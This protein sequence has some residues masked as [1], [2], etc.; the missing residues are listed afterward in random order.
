M[1]ISKT[2]NER[3]AIID[4][5]DAVNENSATI[6][7]HGES[8]A[9]LTGLIAH[10]TDERERADAALTQTL[11]AT[12]GQL[13]DL[14]NDVD[15]LTDDLIDEQEARQ[16]AD[17]TLTLRLDSANVQIGTNT[18]DIATLQDDT[19]TISGNLSTLSETV[20]SISGDVSDITTKL[21]GI[22]IGETESIS[23]AANQSATGNVTF[24]EAFATGSDC[25]VLLLPISTA[26][27]DVF[28]V[29]ATACTITG[30]SY[31]ITNSDAAAHT[32]KIGYVA[33]RTN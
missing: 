27:L 15:T 24:P 17:A 11:N 30:F 26:S 22:K 32:V 16:Q 23:V 31:S 21:A 14:A 12:N 25:I 4:L 3:P 8:I 13:Q 19:E 2:Q 7:Q 33:F 20:T 29:S 5:I 10:E 6:A 1:A 18:D 9:S 28:S